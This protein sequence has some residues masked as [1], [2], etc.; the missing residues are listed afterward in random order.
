M[1]EIQVKTHK[2]ISLK[3][4]YL[5]EEFPQNSHNVRAKRLVSQAEGCWY[6][7]VVYSNYFTFYNKIIG[8]TWSEKSKTI[9]THWTISFPYL[10]I[11]GEK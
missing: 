7:S 3:E 1:Y 11:W 8:R 6:E 9:R 10:K 4:K 2:T 5:N